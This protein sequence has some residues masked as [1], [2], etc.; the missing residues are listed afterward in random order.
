M[1][2][3]GSEI[4][5]RLADRRSAWRRRGWAVLVLVVA[6]VSVGAFLLNRT[7]VF[8][9]DSIEV[10]G[11]GRVTQASILHASGLQEG[12][13]ALMADLDSAEQQIRMLQGISDVRVERMG[14]LGVRITVVERTPAIEVRVGGLHWLLD[15]DGALVDTAGAPGDHLP[16]VI[17]T[18][19]E[20]IVG[21][22]PPVDRPTVERILHLWR[23]LRAEVAQLMLDPE[24]GVSFQMGSTDIR[25]GDLVDID[26]KIRAIML[27][28]RRVRADGARVLV[29]DVSAPSRPAAH[30]VG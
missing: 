1:V 2:T 13:S 27:V 6:T 28:H 3:R 10:V 14:S 16:L 25:F 23:S 22:A 9:I 12:G 11:A 18:G 7:S 19:R 17:V 5:T 26:A 4:A 8:S 30:I 29:L 21:M 24:Q 20:P 15:E